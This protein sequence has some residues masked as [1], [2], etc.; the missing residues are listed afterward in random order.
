MNK[1]N[2][3]YKTYLM[4]T[5][6]ILMSRKVNFIVVVSSIIN[7]YVLIYNLDVGY[8]DTLQYASHLD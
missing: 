6:F 1:N 2:Q 3:K 7:W 8:N 5:C 4:S